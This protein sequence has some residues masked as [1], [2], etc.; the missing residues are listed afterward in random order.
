[1]ALTA[2][3]HPQLTLEIMSSVAQ[4]Q[5]LSFQVNFLVAMT[6]GNDLS[7]IWQEQEEPNNIPFI[8]D[9]ERIFDK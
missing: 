3:C 8:Q 7:V 2:N 9:D 6:Y 4:P 1:M 5:N